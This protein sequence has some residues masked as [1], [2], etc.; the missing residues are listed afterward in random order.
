[1]VKLVAGVLP[2]VTAVAPKKLE[3]VMVTLVPPAVVP[4]FGLTPVTVGPLGFT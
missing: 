2:K 3:P 1:M 4:E